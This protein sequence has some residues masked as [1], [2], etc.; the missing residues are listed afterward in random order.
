MPGAQRDIDAIV[1]A[2]ENGT[3]PLAELQLCTLR[4]LDTI[5]LCVSAQGRS[6]KR[7]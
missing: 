2:V 7:D 6:E 4:V 5:V 1:N 3:L